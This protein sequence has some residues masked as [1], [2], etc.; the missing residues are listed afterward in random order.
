MIG[1]QSDGNTHTETQTTIPKRQNWPL[2]KMSKTATKNP[3]RWINI[4][5]LDMQR[6][7]QYDALSHQV[8]KKLNKNSNFGEKKIAH[9]TH[10]KL[11]NKMCIYEMDPAGIAEDTEQQNRHNFVNRRMDGQTG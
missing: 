9:M 2:V 1:T 11:T 3:V 7:P 10:L 6:R 8:K 4:S 5:Y